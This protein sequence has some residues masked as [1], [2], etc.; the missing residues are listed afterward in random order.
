[1][2]TS[3]LFFIF[4]FFIL[5]KAISQTPV[6]GNKAGRIYGQVLDSV[7]HLPIEY[8]TLT[9]TAEGSKRVI[10]GAVTDASGR[11]SLDI[12]I[13][14]SLK[15]LF[16]SIGYSARAVNHI[17]AD[18]KETLHLQDVF[19][20]KK[21][22]SLE[23]VT[24][25]APA[26]LIENKIDK[27]VY[28][29]EKDLTSQG[30][31]A[32]DILK[33]IPMVSVDV[34]G[35]VELA[36]SSSIRF[37]INGKPSTAFGSNINDVLQSI[38][39]SQIRSIEVITNPGAKYDAE[40][41][42]G[43]IN[44][45]LKHSSVRGTSGSL[46]VSAGSRVENGSFNLDARQGNFGINAFISGNARLPSTT[47]SQSTRLSADTT[48]KT[49]VSLEQDGSSRF[50]RQG[51]ETGI[52][53]D[54]TYHKKNNFSGS[55]GY[56]VFSN[57]SQGSLNQIQ[58]VSDQGNGT[59]VQQ[60]S[61][62][63][64]TQSGFHLDN[65]DASLNYKRTFGKENQELEIALRSSTG[66]SHINSDNSQFI[67]PEDSLYFGN[68]SLSKGTE[69]ETE[70]QLDYTQPLGKKINWGIGGKL[71]FRNISS[72]SDV[73]SLQPA[74]DLYYADTAL[75]NRLTYH[76]KIFAFYSEISLPVGNWFD[77]KI[78]ARYERTELNAYFSNTSAQVPE[79]GYNTWAPSLFFLKKL[80][81]HHTL[82]L[83]YSKRIERPQ[84][85]DLNPF[86]NTVDPKNISSGNPYLKPEIGN[87]FELS[88][89]Y[90]MPAAGSLMF[91]AFYRTSRDD[92][93]PYI[94]YYPDLIVGDTTYTNVAVSTRQ[95]IGLEKDIGVNIFANF[96]VIGKL[97]LRTN[98]FFFQ[99]HT[100]NALDP[101]YN[102]NSFNY[103]L[104]M[105]ISY[106]LAKTLAGEFFGN[107]RSPRNEVQGRY[108]SFTTYTLALRKQFWNKKGSLALT[109]INPF[110]K[111]IDEKTMLFG[112]DFTIHAERKIPF[113]SF[114]LNFTWKFGRLD[115]KK[116]RDDAPDNNVPGTDG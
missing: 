64:R 104:N 22:S 3:S 9:V 98:L 115:F 34:D 10:D 89:I 36:G 16:E 20:S 70:I 84:Y 26:N 4:L 2:K 1:M 30:G 105:N 65:T 53:F 67:L 14:G 47:G 45:I 6:P 29:A 75:S 54:W 83:S 59:L 11:F 58:S 76:Q 41:L 82:K 71:N 111:F 24:V 116:S 63:A 44:I 93:Q 103:R 27:M 99:R 61:S 32:T 113:R 33:K 35:N 106:Q 60:I 19:L 112:P 39:S 73:L 38:P 96:H 66:I 110:S 28:N 31:V 90:S 21:E 87:R 37:L 85:R 18:K 108:P 25:T 79:P 43:I 94:V 107:F 42:G 86:I 69:R 23:A 114:G 91:T 68:Q 78:G 17:R 12:K 77:L 81:D 97:D 40:G 88:Y 74:T 80:N 56:D 55:L 15:I 62:L 95:N 7:S 57:T 72:R 49:M 100:L 109:A 13:T 50:Q 8:A 102:A 92:I 48:A 46:S 51:M 52:G 5:L 101:G